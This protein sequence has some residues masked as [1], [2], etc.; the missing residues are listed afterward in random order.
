MT[1]DPHAERLRAIT[2]TSR[3]V[4][5]AEA[6]LAARRHERNMQIVEALDNGVPLRAV[7]RAARLTP[8]GVRV[9]TDSPQEDTTR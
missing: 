3:S 2:R 5:R 7:A 6:V 4:E 8:R 1:P 9:A